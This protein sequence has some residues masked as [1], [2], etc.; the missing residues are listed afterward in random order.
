MD[1][2]DLTSE[3]SERA[4]LFRDHAQESVALA[5]ENCAA[6]LTQRFQEWALEGLTLEQAAEESGYSYSALQKMTSTGDLLNVGEKG[7]PRLRRGDLP[8][9]AS[10]PGLTLEDG[11]PDLAGEVL[12]R[13]L[14]R[15]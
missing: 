4:R 9:K 6:D 7:S 5:Y 14:S 12:G 3:W 8:K 15:V 11:E 10:K 2:L 13:R 1:P